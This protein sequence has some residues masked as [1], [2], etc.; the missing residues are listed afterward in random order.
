[1]SGSNHRGTNDLSLSLFLSLY[2]L[3]SLGGYNGSISD[4]NGSGD[5]PGKPINQITTHNILI[6]LLTD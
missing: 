2:L 4:Q 5:T 6:T 1:M 3:F